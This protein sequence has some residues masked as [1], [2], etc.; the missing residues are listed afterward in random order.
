LQLETSIGLEVHAQLLTD[1]KLFC[2]W[3]NKYG[4]D[5]NINVCQICMALPGALPVLNN[6]AVN[7]AV[8]SALALSLNILQE[9]Q[10]SRKNYFYPYLPKGYQ[11]SQIDALAA[12]DGCLE[13]KVG[14]GL[15]KIRI[16]SLYLEEDVGKLIHGFDQDKNEARRSFSIDWYG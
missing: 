4:R 14:Q 12:M 10:F 2:S 3:L 16:S 1:T 5:P 9:I 11:I 15:K 13:I 8:K 7:F 6:K